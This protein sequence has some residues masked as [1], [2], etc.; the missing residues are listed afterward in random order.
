MQIA[1][2][3][4]N[5][6]TV[7][8]LRGRIDATVADAFRQQLLAVIGDKP[9]RLLLDFAQVEFISSLGLRVLVVAARRLAAVRGKLLFCSLVGPV[10]EV[11]DLAGFTAVATVFSSREAALASPA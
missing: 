6:V 9:V 5:G 11:F 1:R 7:L 2:Q 10:R 8:V 4:S 3:D